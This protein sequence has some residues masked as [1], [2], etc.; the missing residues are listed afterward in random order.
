ME[1]KNKLFVL[2]CKCL[3]TVSCILIVQSLCKFMV[4]IQMLIK[5]SLLCVKSHSLQNKEGR[6]KTSV[7]GPVTRAKLCSSISRTSSPRVF[8][9]AWMQKALQ[10]KTHPGF[11]SPVSVEKQ[12][13]AADEVL[14]AK[15]SCIS[16]FAL[17]C[18]NRQSFTSHL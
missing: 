1:E 11:C 9:S 16:N 18:I 6:T 10:E 15:R 3:K 4:C 13:K 5:T 17:Q 12:N 2:L 7:R 8:S 14:W